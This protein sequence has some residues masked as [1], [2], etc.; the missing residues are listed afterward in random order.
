MGLTLSAQSK[1]EIYEWLNWLLIQIHYHKLQ[2]QKKSLAKKY[3]KKVT[4]YSNVQIKR[5]ISKHKKGELYWKKWQ[6]KERF[7]TSEDIQLLHYVDQE[8]RLSGAATRKILKRSFEKFH[9]ERYKRLANIS[10]SHIYNLRDRV[11]YRRLGKIFDKTNPTVSNIGKRMKPKPTGKAGYLRVDTVHQGDKDTKKGVYYVNIVDEVTQWEFVFCV[12]AISEKFMIPVLKALLRICPYKIINF[13]SDN[14]SEY[15]NYKL[16]DI[17]NRLH[18][19]QTK[20]RARKHND[21]ALVEGKNASIVRKH[22]GYAH[23]PATEHNAYIINQWC[24]NWLNIYLNY[25]RPC[26]FATIT[27]DKKGKEKKAY[28]YDD[29]NPPYEKL[30]SLS[31]G[32]QYLKK[33]VSFQLLDKIAYNKDDTA[34]AKEMN[35]MKQKMFKNLKF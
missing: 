19:K 11:E 31:N 7:Y 10:V 8:H 30:K 21:N 27:I 12:P 33:S 17:L 23:I 32:L 16:S 18:I 15:I 22:F 3:I 6:K 2:K 29:Y 26:G 34:F 20:S 9:N 13:H 25:H 35:I 5:L 14:G 28:K 4:N 24:I 1:S